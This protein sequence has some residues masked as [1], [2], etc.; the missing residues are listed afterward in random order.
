MIER[1]L[2]MAPLG[3]ALHDAQVFADDDGHM[4]M[5]LV[6]ETPDGQACL[7]TAFNLADNS[8][9]W[10]RQLGG[11]SKIP[12]LS[13]GG[14]VWM[15]DQTGELYLFDSLASNGLATDN[16][17][18]IDKIVLREKADAAWMLPHADGQT[19]YFVAVSGLQ[20]KVWVQRAGLK[21]LAP[22]KI[23]SKL[24]GPPAL[25]GDKIVAPLA[26]GRLSWIGGNVAGGEQEWRG[27]NAD[28]NAA[29]HVVAGAHNRFISTDGSNGVTLWKFDG[30]SLS[31]VKK[32]FVKG[33]RITGAAALLPSGGPNA[34]VRICVADVDR[35]ITLFQGDE[36]RVVQTWQVS[37]AITAGPFVRGNF[38]IVASGRRLNVM[39]PAHGEVWGHTFAA[40]IVGEPQFIDGRLI[41][42]DES[43]AIQALDLAT[44]RIVGMGYRIGANVAPAAVP[45]P[46]GAGRLFV[47]LTDGTVLL[48]AR[49]WF[50]PTFL[51]IPIRR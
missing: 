25:I 27:E 12:P 26:N 8:I 9:R 6:T 37:D 34:E 36:L 48:P 24:A 49:A 14:Q 15:W 10:Q 19:V 30:V 33:G 3:S 17:D 35:R 39:D 2:P 28:K 51:G 43:G 44:R 5:Y 47:P 16:W 21:A 46:F 1:P 23:D 18:Q 22:E 41:V 31:R 11:T 20:A 32:A 38:I 42:A 45:V 29:G 13:L 40:D 50:Q 7:L 4:N